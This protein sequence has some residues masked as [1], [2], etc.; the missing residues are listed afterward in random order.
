V[1]YEPEGAASAVL[2]LTPL[3]L[4]LAGLWVS[5]RGHWTAPLLAAPALLLGLALV[6]ALFRNAAG[7]GILGAL[8]YAPLLLGP[9]IIAI[10]RWRRRRGSNEIN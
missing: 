4:A 10:V 8:V 3:V 1:S 6:A 7:P 5:G 2:L 9:S